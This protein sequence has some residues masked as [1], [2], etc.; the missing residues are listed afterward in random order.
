MRITVEQARCEGHGMCVDAAPDLFHLD[1]D[2]ELVVLPEGGLVPAGQ[3]DR[4]RDA[5][6]VCPIAA[7]ALDR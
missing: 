2:G 6:R 3:E 1:D 5:V 7:L 4:A